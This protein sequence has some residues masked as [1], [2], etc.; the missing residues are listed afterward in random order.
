MFTRDQVP[1]NCNYGFFG[2]WY[3]ATLW[4]GSQMVSYPTKPLSLAAFCL[5]TKNRDF[6]SGTTGRL[7]VD[8]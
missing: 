8:A 1:Q 4:K 6:P 5:V 3:S 7:L 2:V